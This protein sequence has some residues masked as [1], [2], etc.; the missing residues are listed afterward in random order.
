MMGLYELEYTRVPA[1]ATLNEIVALSQHLGKP[2]AGSFLNACL[3][4]YQHHAV[5][6]TPQQE[7]AYY[8]HPLWFISE[9]KQ[10]YPA[11][12]R[13]I[14]ANNNLTSPLI[15]RINDRLISRADYADLLRKD[16]ID[17]R[18]SSLSPLAVRIHTPLPMNQLPGYEEGLVC[19]Q[20]LGAQPAASLLVPQAGEKILDA[21]AAPGNKSS[22]LLTLQPQLELHCADKNERRLEDLKR[23][24]SRMKLLN[25]NVHILHKDLTDKDDMDK[26]IYDKALLDIPCSATGMISR[27]P[28]IKRHPKQDK[29]REQFLML[30]TCFDSLKPGG[31]LLYVS[32]SLLRQENDE[33]IQQ[34]EVS[35]NVTIK[36]I[37]AYWGVAQSRGR[38][39]LPGADNGGF[40][41]SLL[42]KEA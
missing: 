40:F 11:Y 8:D 39:L 14:L 27:Y 6:I 17:F 34:L 32:C 21:G 24:L 29:K 3:R 16:A 30:K 31:T 4:S 19:V 41:Y 18:L 2:W 10:Q 23:N 15:I 35:R 37:S 36:N 42:R 7:E 13:E 12:W 33:V 26:E 9:M 25:G 20:D 38:Q 5:E 1:Y 28:E 22:H